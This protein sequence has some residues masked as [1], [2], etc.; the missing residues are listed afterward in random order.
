MGFR[1]H[2]GSKL[3]SV[4][5]R[6][7]DHMCPSVIGHQQR[8]SRPLS[9]ARNLHHE[10][11]GGNRATL[12]PSPPSQHPAWRPDCLPSDMPREAFEQVLPQG[13]CVVQIWIIMSIGTGPCRLRSGGG[14]LLRPPLLWNTVTGAEEGRVRAEAVCLKKRRSPNGVAPR[15]QLNHFRSSQYRPQVSAASSWNHSR[16]TLPIHPYPS[17]Q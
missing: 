2:R 12:L 16:T 1:H 15:D 17:T 13:R 10:C 5:F 11:R 8:Y 9:W 7:S 14:R 3:L 4:R 6:V